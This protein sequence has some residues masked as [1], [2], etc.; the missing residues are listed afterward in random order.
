MPVQLDS[1]P[2]QTTTRERKATTVVRRPSSNWIR[3]Y[4]ESITVLVVPGTC[5]FTPSQHTLH[6]SF[7]RESI[8]NQQSTINTVVL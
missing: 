4:K 3:Q 5:T 7:L 1:G 2:Q 8:N 6:A